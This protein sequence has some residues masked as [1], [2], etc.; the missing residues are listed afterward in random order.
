MN[1]ILKK[2]NEF[3]K[4]FNLQILQMYVRLFEEQ[5]LAPLDLFLDIHCNAVLLQ[6]WLMILV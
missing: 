5:G 3:K 2:C 4:K 6:P 1:N